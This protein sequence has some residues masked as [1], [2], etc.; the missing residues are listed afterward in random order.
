M[1]A[2]NEEHTIESTVRS[3]CSSEYTKHG[4]S[5]FEVIVVNDGSTDTTGEILS[6]LKEE[7]PELR[8]VTRHPPRSGKGKG[9]VL[10]DALTLS[11]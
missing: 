7:N 2:H 6:K 5:N 11:K 10:N 1:P 3:V 4:E 9:F 8:I